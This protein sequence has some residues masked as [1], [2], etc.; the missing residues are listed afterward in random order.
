MKERERESKR[1]KGRKITWWLVTNTVTESLWKA[2]GK[3]Q[4]GFLDLR[5]GRRREE[6]EVVQVHEDKVLVA[7]VLEHELTGVFEI[8]GQEVHLVLL[9][10]GVLDIFMEDNN[11][12]TILII[13]YQERKRKRKKLEYEEG[14]RQ[15]Q[16]LT[17]TEN[18]AS[19]TLSV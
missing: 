14:K 11:G 17:W 16:M 8:E 5:Q 7:L 4:D 10:L 18:L 12:T 13:T 2:L 15:R 9:T 19:L 6:R 3:H 1:K